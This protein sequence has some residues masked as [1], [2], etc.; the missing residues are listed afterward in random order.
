MN[1]LILELSKNEVLTEAK[2]KI[3]K[4][5]TTQLKMNDS[6]EAQLTFTLLVDAKELVKI[7]PAKTEEVGL[8]EM[9]RSIKL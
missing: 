8:K 9:Q 7:L 6:G 1:Y 5:G 3:G 2:N 4:I